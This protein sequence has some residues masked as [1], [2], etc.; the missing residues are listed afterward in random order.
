MT[1]SPPLENSFP[2]RDNKLCVCGGACVYMHVHICVGV[3][4]VCKC[5]Q[6]PEADSGAILNHTLF[7]EA[8]S[9]NQNWRP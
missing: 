5:M 4:V 7:V 3:C 9:L 1:A 8:E 6:R 2:Y